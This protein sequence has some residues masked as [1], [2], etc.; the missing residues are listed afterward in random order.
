[1]SGSARKLL[2]VVRFTVVR[3]LRDPVSMMMLTI[4]PLLVIPI[5]GT[6]FSR[7][8]FYTT[9]LKGATSSLAFFSIGF[10][11]MFQLFGGRYSTDYVKDTLLTDRKW[12]MHAAPCSPALVAM[13]ILVASTLTSLLQ[14][15]LLVAFTRVILGVRW[16]S[17]AVVAG[18]LLG[19]SL[20]SQL[21][22]LGLLL[23]TRNHGLAAG[24]GW[25]YAWGSSALGGLMFPLPTGNAFWRFMVTYGTPYS[26]AQTAVIRSASG[27]GPEAAACIGALFGLA[28]LLVAVVALLGRR[29]LA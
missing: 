10:V 25:A 7:I 23:L 26:L 22:N 2:L 21:V 19:A 29:R 5:L 28:A 11:V 3:M 14:G 12:R 1:M 24:L 4:M 20:V 17:I 18:V 13:G 15:F 6:V 9:F 8:P 27:A 16:G